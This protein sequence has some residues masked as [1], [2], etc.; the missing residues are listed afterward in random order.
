MLAEEIDEGGWG[1]G[2]PGLHFGTTSPGPTRSSPHGSQM[3]RR[4]FGGMCAMRW[5]SG[6]P[7]RRPWSRRPA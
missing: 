5:P 7:P 2:L 6:I 4:R 1:H 3:R